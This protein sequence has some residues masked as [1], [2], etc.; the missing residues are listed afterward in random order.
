MA[1]VLHCLPE[2]E[3]YRRDRHVRYW[4]GTV[5]SGANDDD[6]NDES[7]VVCWCGGR[8]YWLSS[9]VSAVWHVLPWY[10]GLEEGD[11]DYEQ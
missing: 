6:P 4:Y 3:E 1:T 7:P 11:A 10:E 2:S 8:R 9:E 5:R